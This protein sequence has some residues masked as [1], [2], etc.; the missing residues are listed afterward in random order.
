MAKKN[1]RQPALTVG[2]LCHA[3]AEGQLPATLQDNQ[4][5]QIN[6]RELRR[7]VNQRQQHTARSAPRILQSTKC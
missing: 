1:Q 5:Y 4:W 2:E 7:F 6:A 3:I